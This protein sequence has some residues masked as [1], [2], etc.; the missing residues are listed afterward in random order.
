MDKADLKKLVF[1]VVDDDGQ[2]RHIL[3]EYLKSFGIENVLQAKDGMAALKIV[4]THSQRIDFIISDWEMPQV[5]GLILLKAVRNDPNRESVKFIMVSSQSSR[6]RMKISKAAAAR[7]DAYVVKPF[8]AHVLH[9]KIQTLLSGEIDPSVA[10]FEGILSEVPSNQQIAQKKNQSQAHGKVMLDKESKGAG[11]LASLKRL[12]KKGPGKVTLKA[13]VTASPKPSEV[14]VTD[15]VEEFMGQVFG[16]SP[17][18]GEQG[19]PENYNLNNMTVPVIINLAKEYFKA[20]LFD[21]NIRL[22]LDAHFIYPTSA[23]I[24]FHLALAYQAKGELESAQ[25]QLRKAI[26]IDPYHVEAQTLLADIDL[27]RKTA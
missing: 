27:A 22:C 25:D 16:D 24:L 10:E 7:V 1:V 23:D 11:V 6:E 14:T 3:S 20:S 2:V 8:R 18:D 13:D 17:P 4:Q 19:P 5:D 15:D 12:A 21:K 9:E 26:K